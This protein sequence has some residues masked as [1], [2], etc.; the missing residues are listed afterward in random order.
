MK[1]TFLKAIGAVL[2][3]A[4]VA[5]HALGATYPE[6]PIK[7]VVPFPP[8]GTVNLVAR[9]LAQRL[10]DNLGVPVVV[11][12]KPGAGG[13]IG[14]D[15]VAKAAPD[16][17]TLLLAASSHQSFHHLL[18]KNLPYDPDKAFTQVALF[19]SVPNVLV[20][21]N[22]V[23]AKNVQELIAT[24]RKGKRLFMASSGSGGVNHLVGEY[25]MYR[26]GTGFEH[27]PYKGAGPAMNDLL[28]GQVDL[29]FGNLPGFLPQ[30]QAGKLRVLAVAS[31]RRSPALPEVPTMAEA[32]V[33]DLVVDSWSGVLAPAGTPRP[34]LDRLSTEINKIAREKATADSLAALGAVPMPGTSADYI[35]LVRAET[36]RW[37]D[38]IKKANI[39]IN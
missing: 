8:G 15:L 13:T 1:R 19:A 23:P 9:I 39:S 14:A 4:V 29:M 38:V 6:R 25:F 24:A 18:Y 32:G 7:L 27:V 21:S 30:V 37:T 5:P 34:I 31:A 10:S 16:G 3:A 17:Y 2:A 12:N 36:E 20:V 33:A 28:A 11:E 26:T 22:R 35:A